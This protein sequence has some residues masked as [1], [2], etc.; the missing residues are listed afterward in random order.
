MV[1]EPRYH[2]FL[3]GGGSPSTNLVDLGLP[4]GLLWASRN[5]G[6]RV[7]EEAGLYFSWGN[8][9]GHA[10]GSGYDFSQAEYNTT[11][12]AAITANLSLSQDAARANLGA[13]YRMPIA[14]E[15]QELYDN[16]TSEWT[17][18]N[19]VNGR[20][21]TSNVNGNTLFFPAAG[22]YDGTSINTRGS[23]G[24]YWPSTYFSATNAR[25]LYFNGSN[26]IPQYNYSRR[27]G[28][29]VRA[30]VDPALLTRSVIS[31][32]DSDLEKDISPM[33]SDL[34]KAKSDIIETMIEDE[35]R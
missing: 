24:F 13:P 28:F 17:R 33:D 12:A 3:E 31:P 29:P 19:G 25:C 7:P 6:A 30:V 20:L 11:P 1:P 15:F 32:M 9:I 10:E 35:S 18:I 5:V 4:S 23:S 26:V 21:F 34:E 16:C 8:L 14:A 27:L 22:D 2:G